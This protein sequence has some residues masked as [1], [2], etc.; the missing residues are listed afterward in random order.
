MLANFH[1][2]STFCDGKNTP[3]EMVLYAIEHN[4][5][6]L[7]FSSHGYTDFD[8]R[9]CMKDTDGYI[10]CI[11]KFK[12]KYKDKIEILLGIEEDAFS[13]VDRSKFDYI[14]GSSHYYHIGDKYYPIDSNA[15]YFEKCL[16][17]FDY[18]VLKMAEVYYG[19]FEK[20]IL[21]RKPDIIGHYDVITKFD[22]LGES[23]FL[24]N[25]EY[26]AI[27]ER[28]ITKANQS[29]CLI[30]INT[31]AVA[32][33]VRKTVCPSE[34]LLYTL[35]N[36][37]AKIILSSDSHQCDT[38]DFYFEETKQYLYDIGFRCL[39]TLSKNGIEKYSIK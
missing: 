2:H 11:L 17:A 29:G 25:N 16:I 39:Y 7:G 9:Y 26:K 23:R 4:F 32:R 31:G 21:T 36:N 35:K 37:N 33:G 1:T 15:D 28:Y 20:Y 22:E 14:I 18:D 38:L 27:A 5:S 3:E 8:L 13:L 19:E 6:V 34:H 10:E 30:E 12:E 24:N